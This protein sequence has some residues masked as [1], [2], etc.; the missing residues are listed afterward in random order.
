[1]IFASLAFTVASLWWVGWWTLIPLSLIAGYF[2]DQYP[3]RQW[4]QALASGVA[5]AALAFVRDGQSFGLISRRMSGAFNLPRPELIFG[6]VFV[7]G[8]LTAW[9]WFRAG[10]FLRQCSAMRSA[11][12]PARER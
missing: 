8:A 12:R 10:R 3:S 5:W 9:L 11:M 7:L 2:L 4:Q 6:L 1:M